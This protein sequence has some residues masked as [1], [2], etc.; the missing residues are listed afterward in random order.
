MHKSS[1]LGGEDGGGACCGSH[2]CGHCC[3]THLSTSVHTGL[4]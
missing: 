4:V 1:T 2:S 3:C